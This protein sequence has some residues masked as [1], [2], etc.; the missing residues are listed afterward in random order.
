M[1]NMTIK[2]VFAGVI[3]VGM[4]LGGCWQRDEEEE[5]WGVSA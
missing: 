5:R 1:H 4:S 2:L 3:I